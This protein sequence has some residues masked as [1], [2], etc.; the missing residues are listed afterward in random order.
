MPDALIAR[1]LEQDEKL[2]LFMNYH[3]TVL[4]DTQRRD[5]YHKLL[6]DPDMMA[7][8]AEGLTTPGSGEV[9]QEEYYHRLMQVDYFA[10]ALTWKDNPQRQEVISLTGELIA[11]DNFTGDQNDA[12]R[13]MLG[14]LKMELYRLLY[15]QDAGKTQQLVA[16]AKGTRMEPLVRW[17]AEEELRRRTLEEK[18][19]LRQDSAEQ[20]AKAR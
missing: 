15:E 5:E 2:A 17:M 8:M 3:K 4:L 18:E 7:A 12:R 6:S 20:Q 9:S 1:I 10:A 13:Q 19:K 11:K 14:G 16:Q